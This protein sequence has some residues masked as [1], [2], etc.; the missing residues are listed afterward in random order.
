MAR[1]SPEGMAMDVYTTVRQF[2]FPIN[3]RTDYDQKMD[4]YAFLM[5]H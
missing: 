4:R 5:V 3:V 1:P 2:G